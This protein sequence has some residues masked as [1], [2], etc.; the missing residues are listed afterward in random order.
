MCTL[1]STPSDYLPSPPLI[2][3]KPSSTVPAPVIVV[4]AP[5]G[6][7]TMVAKI[8]QTLGVSLHVDC[9]ATLE[10]SKLYKARGT[11]EEYFKNGS[12]VLGELMRS[13]ASTEAPWGWKDP[14]GIYYLEEIL[15]LLPSPHVVIVTR[16]PTAVSYR[17]HLTNE[18]LSVPEWALAVLNTY[19][20][21]MEFA[22]DP[23]CPTALLSYEKALVHPVLAVGQLTQFCS[24]SPFPEK[25]RAAI[26]LICPEAGYVVP[27]D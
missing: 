10:S 15:P 27:V 5:R 11:L 7:T 1:H 2:T 22:L 23:P 20:T 17:A 19:K 26:E 13:W 21:E 16:D 25:V 18:G 24:L 12:T 3:L 9:R 14:N 6:G 4:G 8:L